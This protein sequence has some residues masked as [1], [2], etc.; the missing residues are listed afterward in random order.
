MKERVS[1]LRVL[2]SLNGRPARKIVLGE[3][4][5]KQILWEEG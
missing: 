2:I 4:I 5:L 1:F 3:A